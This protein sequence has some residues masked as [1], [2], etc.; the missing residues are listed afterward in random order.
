MPGKFDPLEAL[1]SLV[2]WAENER[3][4]AKRAGMIA[5]V[6][7]RRTKDAR[8]ALAILIEERKNEK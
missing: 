3:L 4:T 8:R 2:E 1:E 6:D 5:A 7:A